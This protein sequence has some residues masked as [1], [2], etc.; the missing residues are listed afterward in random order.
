MNHPAFE[1]VHG[2]LMF[3][4]Y[5]YIRYQGISESTHIRLFE[6]TCRIVHSFH[7]SV[8]IY[9]IDLFTKKGYFIDSLAISKFLT[10]R[11]M[12]LMAAT[13]MVVRS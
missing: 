6:Y 7:Y 3:I 11:E 1:W 8:L 13:Y 12:F 10:R 9:C 5:H 4:I 2:I